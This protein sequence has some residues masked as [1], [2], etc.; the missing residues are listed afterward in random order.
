MSSTSSSLYPV[1]LSGGAGSRLW[2]MSREALPKQLLP[3][4]S[5]RTML[6]ETVLRLSNIPKI[7]PPLLVCNNEHR[8]LAAEQLMQIGVKPLALMLEPLARNTAPAIA[9]AAKFLYDTDPDAMMLVLPAD[10]LIENLAA[11]SEAIEHARQTAAQ[12]LLVTFGLVPDSPETGYGYIRKG[13]RQ[14]AAQQ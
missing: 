6:Q 14:P 8:F 1:I 9:A 5:D 2:P 11:F 10:H 12:G 4:V 3:L 13:K 7:A